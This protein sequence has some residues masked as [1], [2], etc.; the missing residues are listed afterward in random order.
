MGYPVLMGSLTQDGQVDLDKVLAE[1]DRK[2]NV[3]YQ[4]KAEKRRDIPHH[5]IH[6]NADLWHKN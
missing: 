3:D 1:R 2:L 6:P 4:Q 5:D